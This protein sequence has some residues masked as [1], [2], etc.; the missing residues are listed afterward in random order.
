MADA[1]A[2]CELIRFTPAP[3]DRSA[4]AHVADILGRDHGAAPFIEG[5]AGCSPFLGALIARDGARARLILDSSPDENIERAIAAAWAASS[6][7]DQQGE[8]RALRRAKQDAALSLALAEISGALS[9]MEAAE[10]L[11]RFAD[12]AIGSA[13]RMALR[14][15]ARL[16]FVAADNE[17][18]E[19]ECGVTVL[20]MGKL[21]AFELNYS[22]DIDLVVLY[23]SASPRLGG[24]D[25][26]KRVAVAATRAMVSRLNDQT[27][28]GYVF[29]TD[30][31]LRPDPG[32]SAA[33]VSINAAET[34]Y[35]SYGQNW[36][37]AAFIK[38]RA[39]AGDSAIGEDFIRRL[40]PFIWRKFLDFA[41]IEE[42]YSVMRQIRTA[43]TAGEA[44]FFGHDLKTGSGG[45]REIEFFA[46][47]QQ[48][49]GGGKNPDLRARGTLDALA[50]LAS[51]GQ[52]TADMRSALADQYIYLRR[53]EHRLQM[54]NDEQTHKVPATPADAARLAAFL[55]EASLA[56]F[57]ARLTESFLTT[58]ALTAPLFTQQETADAGN[59]KLV[60]TGVD[61]D[62]EAIAAL[63]ALGFDRPEFV[64]DAVRRWQAGETRAT[65]SPR[66]RALLSRIAP[67]LISEIAGAASPD[68]AFAAFDG[69]LRGLPAG[70]QIFSLFINRPEVF[71]RLIHIMT[72]SP[73]LAREVAMRPY[74]AE[75]LIEA[76]WPSAEASRADIAAALASRLKAADGFEGALSAVR[77]FS[78]EKQFSAAAQMLTGLIPA[79]SAAMRFTR[80]AE[81]SLDAL[82]SLVA[83]DAA[84]RHGEIDGSFAVIALGRLGA[85]AMTASSDVDLMFVYDAPKSA[86]A[87]ASASANENTPGKLDATT[88]YSRLVRKFISAVTTPT[89]EGAL[90]EVDMQ[91]RPSGSKGPVAVSLSAFRNY[92]ASEA[93]TWELMALTKARVILGAP[94]LRAKI[95]EELRA[96]FAARRDISKVAR[97]VEEMRARLTASRPAASPWDVKL[98]L[99]GLVEIDF[100]AQFLEVAHPAAITRETVRIEDRLAALSSAGL[101]SA[102]D[103]EILIRASVA[104]ESLQ[105]VSRAATGGAFAPGAAGGALSRMIAD[106]FGVDG[107]AA[108]EKELLRLEAEVRAV[109][110]RVVVKAAS[111]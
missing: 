29:R 49:T 83:D 15:T 97:D 76:R 94:A 19:A 43:K 23:D 42:I 53:V 85:Q 81:A 111:A 51:A 24:A 96:L 13:L 102:M 5:V 110:E 7:G 59:S 69:L 10:R 22:S 32:V 2:L 80:I 100:T 34:Y 99:G 77:R 95:E 12:A 31:R 45:I 57:E 16:G 67:Q 14:G 52:I 87:S 88:Y 21:G 20:A 30:L 78:S 106:I 82:A 48:L 104:F 70:V 72:V 107:L 6:A 108:A 33:A 109:Y 58:R 44:A 75:A 11:S 39:S 50:A 73:F 27:G 60:F 25:N 91:L 47:A 41:A 84:S 61:N 55:G 68:E 63:Q 93:W 26:S 90:Y 103:A 66:S 36:E 40:R 92:Y 86:S 56:E 28:D 18:P 79:S 101:L 54:I 71:R 8:M 9:T 105:Q 35:E 38:A 17:R 1:R 46:Q 4:G 98:A 3:F 89:E 37:R 65:R 64:A 62:P 74:L